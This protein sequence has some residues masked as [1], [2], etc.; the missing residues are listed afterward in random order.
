[1]GKDIIVTAEVVISTASLVATFQPASTPEGDVVAESHAQVGM[2]CFQFATLIN[3][4][5]Y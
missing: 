4:L 2:T 5:N 3:Y 1:M